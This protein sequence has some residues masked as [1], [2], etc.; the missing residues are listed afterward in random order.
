MKKLV[1]D[2]DVVIDISRGIKKASVLLTQYKQ[3]HVLY[4]SAFTRYE[5]LVGCRN[6]TEM[7]FILALLDKFNLLPLNE[8]IST[9]TEKLI[10]DY[11]LSHGLK[12]ADALI[13]ATAIYY[14]ADL[15]SKNQKDFR[16]ITDLKLLAYE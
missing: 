3:S 11:A 9:L 8:D 5:V 10:I 13:A 7:R 16:Y 15:I 14:S 2:S 1:V 12:P 6:K 4:V